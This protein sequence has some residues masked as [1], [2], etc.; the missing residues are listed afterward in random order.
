MVRKGVGVIKNQKTKYGKG[1]N[2]TKKRMRGKGE[3][4]SRGDSG[5]ISDGNWDGGEGTSLPYKQSK[6]SSH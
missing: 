3:G 4:W 2:V 6:N 1:Q 5:D